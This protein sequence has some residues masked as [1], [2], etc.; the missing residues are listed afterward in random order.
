[1]KYDAAVIGAG[2]AGS[3]AAQSLSSNGHST[4][5]I[6]P[7]DTKKVC[8]GVLTAR[9][10]GTYPVD[11]NYVQRELKGIKISF[12]GIC[13]EIS[14]R[15]AVEYSIDREVFDSMNLAGA[16]D[17]GSELIKE[18]VLSITE[19]KTGVK[20]HTNKNE[21][22]ADHVIMAA[23]VCELSQLFGGTKQ[24][25]YCTQQVIDQQPGDHFEMELFPGGYSWKVPKK[26]NVLSG[27]SSIKCYPDKCYPDIPGEKGLIPVNGPVKRT[28]SRR[29]LLAGDAAGF[30][31]PF[32][33][34]GIYYARRSG[35]IA[36]QVLS[37][38]ISGNNDVSEY[39]KC[40]KK[41]FDFFTLG[42]L[43][44]LLSSDIVLEA[45]VREIRDNE[46]FNKVV[47]DILT[48]E[49]E[50]SKTKYMLSLVNK[51]I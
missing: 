22:I 12:K 47:E 11:E 50:K 27:T 32:D 36:A 26:E 21:Y 44:R 39:E 35:E 42:K 30:V 51:L 18:R 2:P 46:I 8:A 10:A 14:Y 29:M 15:K 25:A 38:A 33:G 9:Y 40:W 1:M 48:H 28:Y 19:E 43:S 49:S 4:V 13:G 24:Y 34:E 45:F 5:I 3:I 31:S 17:S 7:C 20:I 23:G 6:D 16:L 37:G 41:D